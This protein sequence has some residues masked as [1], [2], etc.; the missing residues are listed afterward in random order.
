MAPS[1][2]VIGTQAPRPSAMR[3]TGPGHFAPTV[4]RMHE[5]TT[6]LALSESGRLTSERRLNDLKRRTA[7]LLVAAHGDTLALAT[8][9]AVYL[10]DYELKLHSGLSGDFEPLQMSL[11]EQSRIYMV[12]RTQGALEL[13]VVTT[14]GQR[15]AR[16]R[17]PS[18]FTPMAPPMVGFD[19]S[20]YLV[21]P[22]GIVAVSPAGK[23]AWTQAPES[24]AGAV[25]DSDNSILV[26]AGATLTRWSPQGDP[27]VLFRTDGERL[28][29]PPS[30]TPSGEL[31]VAGE[32]SIFLLR[33]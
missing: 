33:P 27:R 9:N 25:V 22:N 15:I 23:I 18:E 21:S 2:N 10:A 12:V 31:V 16:V 7:T 28:T 6:P 32:K 30:V 14:A 17:L 13:W 26:S 11:D 20:V 3:R 8:V 1:T 29:T 5:I 4:T 19:H 24:V